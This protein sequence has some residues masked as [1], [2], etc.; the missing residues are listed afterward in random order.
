MHR[1]QLELVARLHAEKRFRSEESDSLSATQ[2]ALT[3]AHEAIVRLVL[4]RDRERESRLN[5]ETRLQSGRDAAMRALRQATEAIR[6]LKEQVGERHRRAEALDAQCHAERRARENAEWRA[7]DAERTS[8]QVLGELEGLT[9]ATRAQGRTI[10]RLEVRCQSLVAQ[11]NQV[12][13]A[14][15]EVI[16]ASSQEQAQLRAELANERRARLAA[17]N[18]LFARASVQ[19]KSTAVRGTSRILRKLRL[20]G[21]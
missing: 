10:A 19:A 21:R 16:Y 2:D 14:L 20:V 9:S 12:E 15:A 8:K 4:E 18:E 11:F 1:D 17:E 13:E 3:K 7:D 5:V 6:K